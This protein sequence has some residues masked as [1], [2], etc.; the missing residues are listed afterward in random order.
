MVADLK[1]KN[2][3]LVFIS[4]GGKRT[5]DVLKQFKDAG[6]TPPLFTTGRIESLAS[7]TAN[8][9]PN[10][11]YQLA[12]DGLPDLYNDRLRKLVS[13]STNP[14]EWVFEGPKNPD[15]E[16][17]KSG[18]CKPRDE[19]IPLNVLDADNLRALSTG[20]QYAD[21][22]S[23][24]AEAAHVADVTTSLPDLRALIV[25]ELGTTY[26]SGRGT[27][28]GRFD[29]WSFQPSSRARGANTAHRHVAAWL[30][31]SAIGTDAIR[32]SAQPE[33]APHRYASMPISISSA[34][35]A[36]TTTIRRSSRIFIY[37]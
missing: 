25:R 10:D 36:S 3:D 28:K 20:T 11:I 34:P 29:N 4:V 30:G 12:W 6:F 26:A 16:G 37:P 2:A 5:K 15:A 18:Q 9:Y 19:D 21:I 7:D 13:N 17:W 14:N 31:P 1:A 24:I 35:S 33:P 8:A 27:F 23:L 32:P 22:V